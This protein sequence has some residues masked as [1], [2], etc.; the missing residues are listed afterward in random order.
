M[1]SNYTV[2][3]KPEPD[4]RQA[5]RFLVFLD[6][7]AS[8]FTFQIFPDIHKTKERINAATH[9]SGSFT[10]LEPWLSEMNRQGFGVFVTINRTDLKGRRKENIVKVRAV[11]ADLDG[12]P[13]EPVMQCALQP[14][15]IVESSPGRYHV[16]WLVNDLPMDQFELVQ[17]AIAKRFGADPK[18]KDLSRVLR[19]P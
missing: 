12:S 7:E 10:S 6:P 14:H 4:I 9:R 17:S 19:V 5:K 15:L 1:N 2:D 13:L 3:Y 18:C 11:F 8:A 16:F